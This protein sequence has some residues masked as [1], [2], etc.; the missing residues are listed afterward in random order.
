[1][2]SVSRPVAPP[3]APPAAEPPEALPALFDEGQLVLTLRGKPFGHETFSIMRPALTLVAQ[4][5]R[6][7]GRAAVRLLQEM[8]DGGKPAPVV[9]PARLLVRDST[10]PVPE[11]GA[12]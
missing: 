2:R 11:G 8:I 5:A 1:M 9:L 10:G 12:R 6:E 3:A 4:D 7:M